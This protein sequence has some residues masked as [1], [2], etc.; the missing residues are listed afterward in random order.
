MTNEQSYLNICWQ[1]KWHVRILPRPLGSFSVIVLFI[2]VLGYRL[3]LLL[4]LPLPKWGFF[5]LISCAPLHRGGFCELN[6]INLPFIIMWFPF[7]DTQQGWIVV[8]PAQETLRPCS[9]GRDGSQDVD[10]KE[11]FHS[12]AQCNRKILQ[13]RGPSTSHIARRDA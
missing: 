8:G 5:C 2:P 13:F 10:E 9:V 3:L 1:K 7:A 4:I 12:S 11:E 6:K